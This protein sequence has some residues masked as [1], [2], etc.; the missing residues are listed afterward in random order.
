MQGI[1]EYII[2]F[3]HTHR[4]TVKVGETEYGINPNFEQPKHINR[5]GKVISA[6]IHG[7]PVIKKGWEVLVMH[8]LLLNEVYSKTGNQKSNFCVDRDKNYFRIKPNLIVMYRNDS[9][10]NWKCH[11]DVVMVKPIKIKEEVKTWNGY[12]LPDSVFNEE[13]GYKGNETRKGTIAF[14]NDELA[15]NAIFEGDTVMFKIDREYEFEI[16]GETYYQM[17]TCD[18]LM[19]NNNFVKTGPQLEDAFA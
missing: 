17:E 9:N 16:E 6:P 10:D 8:T 2:G 3:D 5:I 1:T 18:L 11:M 13:K 4:E 15:K 7:G 19:Y 14:G 12:E